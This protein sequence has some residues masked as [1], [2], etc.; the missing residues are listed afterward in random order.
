V[1][2][3]VQ[4]VAVTALVACRLAAAQTAPSHPPTFEDTRRMGRIALEDIHDPVKMATF[5]A[6]IAALEFT[7]AELQKIRDTGDVPLLLGG[8][9]SAGA[10]KNAPGNELLKLAIAKAP[11]DPLPLAALVYSIVPLPSSTDSKT[12]ELWNTLKQWQQLEPE[13]SVPFYL[14][15]PLYARMERY[16]AVAQALARAAPRAKFNTYCAVLRR[17]VVRAAESVGYSRFAARYLALAS[18]CGE[19]QFASGLTGYLKWEGVDEKGARDC[20][21][22]GRRLEAESTRFIGELVALNIQKLALQKLPDEAAAG[23]IKRID[24]RCG[25]LKKAEHRLTQLEA[26]VPEERFVS[27]LDDLLATSESKAYDKLEPV[28]RN[29]LE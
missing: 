2:R 5:S 29:S 21:T 6:F 27:Y 10:P 20:L 3:M 12:S 18:Q 24:E 19:L 16:D 13:N 17:G 9:C 11:E 8:G 25:Y 26:I 15:A 22:L 14:E 7:P 23:E 1:N 4:C 28:Y